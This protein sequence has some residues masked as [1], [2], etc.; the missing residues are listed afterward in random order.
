MAQNH[1]QL[2]TLVLE[3]NLKFIAS[4]LFGTMDINTTANFQ[5]AGSNGVNCPTFEVFTGGV[6]I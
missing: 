6:E 1:V 5:Q 4:E 3:M 2:Q